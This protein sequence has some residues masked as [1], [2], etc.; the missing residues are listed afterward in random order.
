[1]FYQRIKHVRMFNPCAHRGD[2]LKKK[3]TIFHR[4]ENSH[5]STLRLHATI[6]I[7]LKYYSVIFLIAQ[8]KQLSLKTQQRFS[9]FGTCFGVSNIIISHSKCI[10]KIYKVISI[11]NY[12]YTINLYELKYSL[13]VKLI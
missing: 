12:S 11:Y 5:F 2:Y 1:M 8:M 10:E 7:I 6:T 9:V 4:V 3:K 13:T